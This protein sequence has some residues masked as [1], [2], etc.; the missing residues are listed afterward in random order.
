MIIPVTVVADVA[1][2]VVDVVDVVAVRH[3]HVPAPW[4]VLVV[5]RVVYGVPAHLA[6]VDMV[7]VNPVQVAVVDV[8][9]VVAVRHRDMAASGAMPVI[10][11]RVRLMLSH[12]HGGIPLSEN[13]GLV[14]SYPRTPAGGSAPTGFC[15]NR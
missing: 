5:V 12:C 6:L 9:D 15:A 11:L 3:G 8:V 10:V 13:R 4:L 1:V 14:R 7:L 2:P